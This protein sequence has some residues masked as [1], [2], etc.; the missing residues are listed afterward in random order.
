MAAELVQDEAWLGPVATEVAE[1]IHR[2][3]PQLESDVELAEATR[4]S[5][6]DNIRLFVTMLAGDIPAE[7]AEPG[8]LAR[9]Y[10][11]LVV[12]RRL[13]PEVVAAA[14]RLGVS[15]FWQPWTDW[16]RSRAG[17]DAGYGE[18]IAESTQYIFGW[19][20][21]LTS[22]ALA[23]YDEERAQWIRDPAAVRADTI[24]ALLRGGPLDVAQAERR[25]GYPLDR[26]HRCVVVWSEH[27]ET[28]LT[29]AELA[30]ALAAAGLTGPAAQLS[31]RI[32][33]ST[34]AI[35][36]AVQDDATAD[37]PAGV[38]DAVRVGVGTPRRGAGGFRES[39]EEAMHARRVATLLGAPAGSVTTYEAI[40]LQSIASADIEQARRFTQQHLGALASDDP[41]HAELATT[42]RVYLAHNSNLRAAASALGIHHNTVSNRLRRAE[43]LL[44]APLGGRTAQLLVALELLP[45]VGRQR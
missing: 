25:L 9:N 42:L 31:L 40:A 11:R 27:P 8:P 22:R 6:A 36:Q 5:V 15:T 14:Y 16:L 1:R 20:D 28:E 38:S 12:E 43:S 7:R 19:S 4:D 33:P 24:R 29:A 45:V 37:V 18:A 23:I 2:E 26:V 39:H 30:S 3:L 34:T 13:G 35:W 10:L 44:T 41:A 17:A 32:S 21:A